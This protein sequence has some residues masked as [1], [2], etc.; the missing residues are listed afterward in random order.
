MSS[1]N[2]TWRN[3]ASE[4]ILTNRTNPEVVIDE[5]GDVEMFVRN[6]W[7]NTAS[8][9][10]P[11]TRTL[12]ATRVNAVGE[13]ETFLGNAWRT[14]SS[15]RRNAIRGLRRAAVLRRRA[16]ALRRRAAAQLARDEGLLLEEVEAINPARDAWK[17]IASETIFNHRELRQEPERIRT[18]LDIIAEN[19]RLFWENHR[20]EREAEAEEARRFAIEDPEMAAAMAE[21][22]EMFR[23]AMSVK[24]YEAVAEYFDETGE[25]YL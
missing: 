19:Q 4:T 13:T 10:I 5:D 2:N 18:V 3:T 25:S 16:E 22:L 8:E 7:R 6:A 23:I 1:N 20:K 15:R 9:T 21:N 24:D 14:E 17:R 11:I 12:P